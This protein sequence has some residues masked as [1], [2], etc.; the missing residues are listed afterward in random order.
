MNKINKI[1]NKYI[2]LE[3]IG[4]GKFGVIYKGKNI[5]TN[6]FVA[7][8]IESINNEIKLLK[9]ESYVYNYLNGNIGIPNVKWFGKDNINYYMVINLLGKSL[10]DL[11]NNGNKLKLL[12]TLKIGVKIVLI[13]KTIHDYGFVH[14]DIKPDNFLFSI[15]NINL[16]YL[17]DFGFCKKIILDNNHL[18]IKKTTGLIGSKNYASINSHNHIELSR[19]DDLESIGYVLLYLYIGYLPWQNEINETNICNIK[20]N[21]INYKTIPKVLTDFIMYARGLEYKETPNYFLI[22]DLFQRER[23]I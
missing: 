3:K 12:T 21:I 22:I 18:E 8:K 7:V 1:N 19:R 2:L 10:K 13:I 9:H 16:L 14:R 15:N 5:R 6:E 20:K 17:I 4:E 11:I 23:L